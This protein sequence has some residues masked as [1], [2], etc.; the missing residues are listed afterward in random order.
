MTTPP[1][2]RLEEARQLTQRCILAGLTPK[3]IAHRLNTEYNVGVSWRTIY[4][5]AKGEHA[6]Q[7]ESDIAALRKLTAKAER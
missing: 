6:P 4:R 3:S 7:R 2:E 5:W 1:V